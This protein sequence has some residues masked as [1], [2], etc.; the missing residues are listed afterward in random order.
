MAE[1]TPSF[2]ALNII[3]ENALTSRLDAIRQTISHAGE[4]G[5]SL[6]GEIIKLLRAFLPDEYG[7]STGFIA[8][9]AHNGVQLSPQLDVIV[10]DAIRSGPIARLGTCDVFPLEAAYAYVEVKASIQ[11]TSNK[12]ENFAGNS[13]EACILNNKRL[14]SMRQRK[15]YAPVQGSM[16][17]AALQ[18][19]IWAPI[20]GFVFAFEAS[21]NT[22]QNPDAL[23]KRISEFSRTTR[24][25]HLHGVFVGQ[26]AFYKTIAVDPRKAKPEDL[27]HVE[28]TTQHLLSAFKWS[29]MHSLSRFPRHKV[30]AAAGKCT[31]PA[32]G[33]CTTSEAG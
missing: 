16:S 25:V 3:E 18:T 21:G 30:A 22:A 33:K 14:R 7:L 20:R 4:K 23:A 32:V 19:A 29:L 15:Y 26:S 10:Y 6:E 9:H 5:R 17:E 13:I 24:D 27:C 2:A 31:T 1:Y 28:F 11:S 8:Y 12:A